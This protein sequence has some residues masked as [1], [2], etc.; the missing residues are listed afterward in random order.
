MCQQAGRDALDVLDYLYHHRMEPARTAATLAV[1]Q[2]LLNDL[3]TWQSNLPDELIEGLSVRDV[4]WELDR[5]A[6]DD[7]DK[8]TLQ[9]A[10]AGTRVPFSNAPP[11][12]GAACWAEVP[13]GSRRRQGTCRAGTCRH[14][15]NTTQASLPRT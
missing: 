9:E 6:L 3:H 14:V 11:R 12:A 8:T 1:V 15:S 10:I 13:F 7:S 5:L 4:R 2:G